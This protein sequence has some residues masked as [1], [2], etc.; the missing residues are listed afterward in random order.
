VQLRDDRKRFEE[1]GAAIVLIGLGPADRAAWF[2]EDKAIPFACLADPDKV[3]YAA[4]GLRTA[5]LTE[6]LRAENA[7]KYIRLNLN[8]ETRQRPAKAGEDVLQLGGTF[9]VDT[10][11]VIRYAHRNRH[12]GDNP[13]DDEVLNALESLKGA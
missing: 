11:G 3:A 6:V 9:V 8:R 7:L 13:P 2:C 1:A 12:T 10:G 4:Y 5:T